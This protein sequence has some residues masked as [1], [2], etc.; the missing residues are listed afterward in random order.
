MSLLTIKVQNDDVSNTV[1]SGVSIYLYT[2]SSVFVTSG[3]TNSSGVMTIDVPIDTY[4]LLFFKQ[5]MTVPQP[6]RIVMSSM[7]TNNFLVTGHIRTMPESLDT[8]LCK[9][10]GFVVDNTGTKTKDVYVRFNPIYENMILNGNQILNTPQSFNCDKRGYFE[11]DLVRTLKYQV[12]IEGHPWTVICKVPDMPSINLFDL[13]FPLPISITKSA[14]TIT[15]PLSGGQNT[16]VTYTV[17]YSDHNTGPLFNNWSG[18]WSIY[19]CWDSNWWQACEV[20]PFWWNQDGLQGGWSI[21]HVDNSNPTVAT[22]SSNM[23]NF[24]INPLVTGST[25]I[26]FTRLINPHYIWINGPTFTTSTLTITVI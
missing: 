8:T 16:S 5:A 22:F 10:S 13:I 15:L 7:G 2:T 23:T 25:T 17:N 1:V 24:I 18:D 19:N 9:V 4:D 14:S 21:I 6:Q 11:F 3:T 20:L 12:F 26:T